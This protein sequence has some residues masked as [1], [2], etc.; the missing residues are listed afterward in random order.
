M[1]RTIYFTATSLDGFIADPDNSLDWLFEVP[2][3]EGTSDSAFGAFF[4]GVGASAMGATTYE[5]VLREEGFLDEPDKWTDA[6]G[7]TPSWVFTHRDLPIVPGADIRLVQ[8][9]VAPVHRDMVAAADGRNVWIVGGGDLAGAFADQGLLNEIHLGVQ[10][11]FLDGGAPLLPRRLTSARVHLRSVE[12]VGQEVNL[13][14][15]LDPPS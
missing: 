2:R 9:D 14:Y 13:V 11:V 12:H 15:D 10:P 6:F 1:T 3:E 5:W 7:D 8:G 4:A